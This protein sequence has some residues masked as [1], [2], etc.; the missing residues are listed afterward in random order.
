MGFLYLLI[1]TAVEGCGQLTGLEWR[2]GAWQRGSGSDHPITSYRCWRR[3][4]V[5]QRLTSEWGVLWGVSLQGAHCCGGLKCG[6][7]QVIPRASL[8]AHMVKNLPQ[9]RRPRFDPWVSKIPWRREWQPTAVFLPGEFQGQRS[10]A[11]YSHGVTKSWTWLRDKH[12][13]VI[14]TST[15]DW[16]VLPKSAT[17]GRP[18]SFPDRAEGSKSSGLT[19][20]HSSF[21]LVPAPVAP[22]H[23]WLFFF[24]F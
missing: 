6:N 16:T 7:K 14:Q 5:R 10:L 3:T 1:W 22:K 8:A 2:W 21:Q 15:W 9:C 23:L 11:G 17:Q 18:L 19:C 12:K 13:Q 24:F 20:L 4:S